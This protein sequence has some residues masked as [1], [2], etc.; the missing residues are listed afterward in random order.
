MEIFTSVEFYGFLG[1]LITQVFTFISTKKASK[2]EFTK[3]KESV[4]KLQD[5]ND[6][7]DYRDKLIREIKKKANEVIELKSLNNLELIRLFSLLVEKISDIYKSILL[8][9]FKEIDL[10]DLEKDFLT[11]RLTLKA[12]AKIEQLRTDAKFLDDLDT[13]ILKPKI[14]L[15]LSNL[16]EIKTK[17]NG[18]FSDL[19]SE[20]SKE[21]VK[22][23]L[24]ET[25][26]KYRVKHEQ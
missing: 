20:I 9:G 6:L 10:D 1:V 4:A 13:E 5:R 14:K 26:D 15:Y 12:N 19:F 18:D 8:V 11:T 7:E 16:K 3:I 2:K 25:I 17:T 23:I 21:L 22:D 24:K